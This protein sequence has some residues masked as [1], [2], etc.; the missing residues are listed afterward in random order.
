[1]HIL[2]ENDTYKNNNIIIVNIQDDR[3][4]EIFFVR[5]CDLFG[6]NIIV[7]MYKAIRKILKEQ[8]ITTHSYCK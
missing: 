6:V 2:N 7:K 8:H 4:C 5:K 3:F 1:M